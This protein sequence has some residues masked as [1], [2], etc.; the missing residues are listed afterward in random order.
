MGAI[1]EA[2]FIPGDDDADIVITQASYEKLLALARAGKLDSSFPEDEV[3]LSMLGV[4][5]LTQDADFQ[6]DCALSRI[7][8]RLIHRK[9]M[10]YTDGFLL[11]DSGKGGLSWGD[12]SHGN[13]PNMNFKNNTLFPTKKIM[14]QNQLVTAPHMPETVLLSIYGREW[15]TPMSKTKWSQALTKYHLRSRARGANKTQASASV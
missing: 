7:P 6:Q 3:A 5:M 2:K 1:R 4:D 13:N 9:T 11:R 8:L 12:K 14:F 15:G 10:Y